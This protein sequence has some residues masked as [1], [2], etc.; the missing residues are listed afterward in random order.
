MKTSISLCRFRFFSKLIAG[1]AL[2]SA[3]LWVVSR[4]PSDAA[5]MA[6]FRVQRARFEQLKQ[7]YL[8]DGRDM[9]LNTLGI[10][11]HA[12]TVPG[13][14]RQTY[15]RL[16]R[17]VGACCIDGSPAAQTVGLT[18]YPLIPWPAAP[19]KGY[20]YTTQPPAWLTTGDTQAYVFQPGQLPT[21]CRPLEANWYLC[22]SYAD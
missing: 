18:V 5:L 12:E 1:L 16:L 10:T 14:R 22:S 6:N 13:V 3:G 21:I 9:T 2:F 20:L 17:Q 4:P 8:G 19:A 7:M 15:A 11:W